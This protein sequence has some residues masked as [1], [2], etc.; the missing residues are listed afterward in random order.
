MRASTTSAVVVASLALIAAGVLVAARV[1]TSGDDPPT[2][3]DHV[4]ATATERRSPQANFD[5]GR[6]ALALLPEGVKV[7]G[8]QSTRERHCLD[9][10]VYEPCAEFSVDAFGPSGD[11]R[12]PY[13]R[14]ARQHGWR[15]VRFDTEENGARLLLERGRLR[16]RITLTSYGFDRIRVSDPAQRRPIVEP[17]MVA[18]VSAAAARARF[19]GAAESACGRFKARIATVPMTGISNPDTFRRVVVEFER[20]V[21]EI[22]SL[23]VPPG[24]ERAVRRLRT[25]LRNY[26]KVLRM[27][28]TSEEEE[29]LAAA[30]GIVVQGNRAEDAMRQYGLRACKGI[31]GV[32]KM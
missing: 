13:A 21:T 18:P 14:R 19:V 24:E 32:P 30:T 16:A 8:A 3:P 17:V 4:V 12:G 26:A 22:A 2:A 28:E 7:S 10:G 25:E 1:G 27:L 20:F 9:N 15:V 5:L 23:R 6:E 11:R 29:A 31:T